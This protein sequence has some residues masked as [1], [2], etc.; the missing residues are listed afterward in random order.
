MAITLAI[1]PTNL[2]MVQKD[3]FEPTRETWQRC[4]GQVKTKQRLRISA[5][6]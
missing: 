2:L 1:N 6:K 4:Y 5:V 3:D